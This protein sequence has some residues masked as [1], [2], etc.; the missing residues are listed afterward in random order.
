MI[1]FQFRPLHIE[2]RPRYNEDNPWVFRLYVLVFC[3][4]ETREWTL[5]GLILNEIA[6][7]KHEYAK[8]RLILFNRLFEFGVMTKKEKLE[9][10]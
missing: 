2:W 1:D 6:G 10:R 7:Y 8:V 4:T 5:F 9:G 3:F